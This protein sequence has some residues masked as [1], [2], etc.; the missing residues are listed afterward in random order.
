VDY[1]YQYGGDRST[2]SFGQALEGFLQLEGK[3]RVKDDED[4]RIKTG[5]LKIPKLKLLS[6]LSM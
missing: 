1:L 2:F 5:I 6:D 3:T 4:G